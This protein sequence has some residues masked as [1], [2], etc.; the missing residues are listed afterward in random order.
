[1]CRV[2]VEM[3]CIN[4]EATSFAH[5]LRFD[6]NAEQRQE[7]EMHADSVRTGPET[8][9]PQLRGKHHRFTMQLGSLQTDRD[10]SAVERPRRSL[11]H[12]KGPPLFLSSTGRVIP[13]PLVN[14]KAQWH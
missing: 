1:M 5:P 11:K 13:L 9:S 2:S 3:V 7:A 8:E 12:W 14:D 10:G 6:T 4:L